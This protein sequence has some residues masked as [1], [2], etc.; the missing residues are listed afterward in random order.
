MHQA[1]YSNGA[2]HERL[3]AKRLDVQ[4]GG[5]RR[6]SRLNRIEDDSEIML[7]EDV[8]RLRVIGDPTVLT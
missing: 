6:Q 8:Y 2:S 1:H 4:A 5:Y 3:H 7:N